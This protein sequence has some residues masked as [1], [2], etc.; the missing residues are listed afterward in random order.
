M[1]YAAPRDRST[2]DRVS[3]SMFHRILL[4]EVSAVCVHSFRFF[5]SGSIREGPSHALLHEGRMCLLLAECGPSELA[6]ECDIKKAV[7][8]CG[9][10]NISINTDV[11][12]NL[13][14]SCEPKVTQNGIYFSFPV[15]ALLGR[16]K[17]VCS[18]CIAL[19]CISERI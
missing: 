12:Q 7:A 6:E 5:R 15:P 11:S 2:V 1:P 17:C 13:N 19:S 10:R 4:T 9:E 14:A 16:M 3:S 8:T 18:V